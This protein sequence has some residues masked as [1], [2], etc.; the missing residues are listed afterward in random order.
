MN[1]RAS[2]IALLLPFVS[3][4]GAHAAEGP[5]QNA[6][7]IEEIVVV[8][9]RREEAAQS[10]PIPISA[11]PDEQLQE[12]N[13]RTI[14]Q[15][16]RITPNMTFNASATNRSASE[17]FL[18]GIGQ[19]NIGPS[20]DPK[21][22]MYV[23]GVYLGRP[24]GGI[25]DLMDVERIE[26]L[27]GPQGTLFGRNTTA[28]LIHVITKRPHDRFEAVLKGGAGN[29]GQYSA[30]GLVNVPLGESVAVRGAF[31][32]RKA[33][34]WV[35]D[36]AGR[37]WNTTDRQTLRA[38]LLWTPSP[39]FDLQLNLDAYRAREESSLST[40][41]F[42]G[43][44]NGLLS[45]GLSFFSFV[46]GRYDEL[47]AACSDPDDDVFTSNDNDPND[48]KV[49][50]IAGSLHL[51][52]DFEW[53]TLSS[54]S[55]YRGTE[56]INQSWGW[57]T[58]FAGDVSNL[59]EITAPGDSEY[60]QYSQEIRLSGTSF[61]DAL[62]WT[63]GVFAF[64]EDNDQ[65]NGIA[66]YRDAPIPTPE[67]SPIFHA[68]P[69]L[70]A[71]ALFLQAFGS[72][73]SHL[74]ATNESQAVFGEATYRV[75]PR[76]NITAGVRYTRDE[77]DFTRI[78]TLVDGSFDPLYFC[79]G[80]P[81]DPDTGTVLSDRCSDDA[82]FSETTPRLILDY[83]LAEGTMVY[84]SASRGYASGGHN[85]DRQLQ[86]YDPETSDN[87]ELG[88]KS[89]LWDQRLRLNATS[90][91]TYYENQQITVPRSVDGTVTAEI[92]NAEESKIWGFELEAMVLPWK[93]WTFTG[94]YGYL[95]GEYDEFTV[96]DRITDPETGETIII[97]RDLT[98]TEFVRG[99][100]TTYSIHGHYSHKLNNGGN[101]SGGVGWSY[102]G[103]QYFTLESLR[104]SRQKGYGTLDARFSYTLAGGKASVALWGTNLTD[105]EY[106]YSA[107]DLSSGALAL[108][109]V[110][111]FWGQPRRFGIE[112]QYSFAQQ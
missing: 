92:I 33:D 89:T 72:G 105:E 81:V 75:T 9:R 83:A 23:D 110:S 74:E 99:S 54:I 68:V 80:N 48:N 86:P 57:G 62:D 32:A 29:D 28:G 13:I 67:E 88:I 78:Q 44:D 7:V 96:Q 94:S 6:Q 93:G 79:R 69:A 35:E 53:G 87:L 98:D 18:R 47:Q 5:G 19:S 71:T 26:V 70:G 56:S 104:T 10:V 21:I 41:E 3:P 52:W 11:L 17:V 43:P 66:L 108:G 42:T 82:G 51:N 39:R 55:A 64:K 22:G 50:V 100:P 20:Q 101:V 36:N 45:E 106:F 2:A 84:A 40:C 85:S 37:E 63:V 76:F 4:I 65:P 16:E 61:N 15:I 38:S 60:D 49:D 109:T 34:G 30:E 59:L 107:F 73:S 102:R 90:F 46:L 25:F 27:R 91:L 1:C 111:K 95:D 77:R 12:R 112:F 103:R 24:Q 8:A 58:D 14:N 31:Q 97:E